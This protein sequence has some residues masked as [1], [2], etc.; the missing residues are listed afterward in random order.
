MARDNTSEEEALE[1]MA[2]A[3]RRRKYYH[4]QHCRGKWGDS[5]NYDLCINSACLGIGATTDL[6]EGYIR[7]RLALM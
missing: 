1:L 2:R 4:N 5:R 6:L 3:D 7:S